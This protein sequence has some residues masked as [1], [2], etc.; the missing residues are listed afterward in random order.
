MTQDELKE[1]LVYAPKTG[2]FRWA[3]S[4]TPRIKVGDL[5]G[6]IEPQ[7]YSRI[8]L[9]GKKYYAHRLATLYMLGEVA[10]QVDHRR[11]GYE[12]KR[13]NRWTN[14]RNAS[15][16]QNKRNRGAQVNNKLG[17]KN[18]SLCSKSGKYC[19]EVQA[20]G[21]KYRLGLYATPEAASLAA[22]I[23]AQEVHGEFAYRSEV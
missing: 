11:T 16:S 19:A 5:A 22:N 18:V 8:K 14:L 4:P 21:K 17:L 10:D 6:S 20:D 15:S 12:A 2:E 1:W 7:G 23:M 3:K 13:D 9:G